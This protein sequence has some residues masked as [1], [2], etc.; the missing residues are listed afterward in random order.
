MKLEHYVFYGR[1]L[2]KFHFRL[3]RVAAK[4][5]LTVDEVYTIWCFCV[6][7]MGSRHFFRV[8]M[9]D[10]SF[11]DTMIRRVLKGDNI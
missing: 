2:I 5:G 4:T 6:G 8:F 7:G 11:R 9:Q 1:G 10:E 3:Q